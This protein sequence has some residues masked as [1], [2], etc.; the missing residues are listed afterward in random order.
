MLQL[1]HIKKEYKTGDL[2]QKALDDVSL[3][4][5]DNEF[6]AI[7]GPS[8]SGKTT[9]L[10]VIGGLDRYDSGDLIIN[11]IS[12]KKYTD[13]DWDSYRNHT[14]GFVFQSYN[15]I[16]H[17]TVLSNVE[18]ALTISGISGA[19]RRSRATKA[20]EQVGLGDQLHKHPSEMSGGQ[21]QRVAI[22]RALVNNPDILLA[23]EPT[24]ALDSDTSIQVMELLKEVAKDR[25]VVMVTHNPE[26]AEQYATRI[27]RLRDGV[28]QSD[29]A[30]FTPDDSA[31]VPPVHKNL[32]HSSM[33]PL[34]ALAL[35]FN[36]LLTKKTRTLLTAFAGSIGIIGI[37]LILSLSAGVSNYIQEMERSTLS[38]Y[39][40]QISTTGVDLAALL[41]PGSYTSA[42]ANNTN[43]GATS[44]SSTPEG[45][46]TVRELLSQ[47]TEDNSSVNDLASLKKYLDSDECTIS[48]DAASIEY[49]YGIAPLIYRQ[50]K[51]GTVRQIFPDSS[52]SALNNTTSA[53]GIVSS[54][55][56]QSVFTEMAEEPSLYEDQ[57]DVKAGRWP[58]SYNEAV[59]VLNSDGSISDY[60]LYILGIEDDSV[61]MRFLQEYAKNK[62]TQAPTGYGTYPYDT[63]VGLKYKIVTSSDYYVYDEERQIWR[64]R[65]DDEAYVEQLVENSPDLTI[66]G[67]VQPR[68]DAS[69]TIL[70]IGVA[71]THA[72]TYYAIDHAAESEVV[73]QQLA[74]PEVNVLTGERFDADQ[75]ETDLDIS[76]LFSVDTD[77]LKDAFQFDASKLQFD[78]SGA[79]DLQDGSFDF[80][81]ILD[82]SAFQLDLS[83]LDLSDIDMS[84]VELPDMDA[85]DLSQ[86]FADM[87]LSV[88]EDALQ[89]L[90]KKI[91]NGYKR[92]IIG[93]GILNLDKIG[94]SSY[95][96][97][98]QFKQL[99]SES[100]GDLLDTTGLQEQFT[101]SL[102]QNLQGIMTS[103]LQSYSEQ[104]SQKL[105]EALQTKLTAAI[106]TQMSTVMQQLMTQLTTQFSQQIQ[107]AIQNNIA[108]L[109]S[110]VE[111]ALK[112]DPT[113]FQSAVQVNMST[114]DLVDLV[115]MNLQ[116]STT[117]YSSVLGAL[118]YSD[119]AKPGSIWIYPKSFEA[120]NRI[121][122]SL[123][124]YNAA[125]RAQGEE[126]KVIVFSD[127][128]GTLMS[129]VT[130]I[131]DMVSNVLVAF[132]A[133][134]LAV[135]SIMIGVITYISVL[136]RRKEIGILRAI[137]ASK[138]N[139]SEVFNAE[140]FIIGM[141]SGV[142]GVGLCLLL[143]IPGNML[144]H[145]IAGTT[146]VTAVLPPKA[147]LVLIVLA[148][149]LTILGGLIPARSAAK[150]NP[151][152]AL[153][154]E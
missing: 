82:P 63:F 77:M 33:S 8:G 19:E 74:D 89:S 4:L 127:T 131:V 142:I 121:V 115:K 112:I 70:P 151:V 26:L 67:V 20:L 41:D 35:S 36:N 87:D 1:N 46:V 88:S 144:I 147:A 125:M 120:K 113:V 95:M 64:N 145:S 139:V 133:I 118:G 104:L 124:A 106:Q 45:M 39:P 149:L 72:L 73:K 58:E 40:L 148:T 24:G 84:D 31:Q 53:A 132:V 29:T 81:S 116:S 101:A 92:Y 25:L 102:Q 154:S 109:S 86:L 83:D 57:Y 128:V 99:L 66:V 97:S 69:S 56:N 14:I 136:E 91:M 122:D 50:N 141:C 119:Y 54:M 129:A 61:M 65:S 100:M 12:T 5:R 18:L 117:S 135:S 47:L 80:S 3:N 52:L 6:V 16:P 43:V 22:A 150:C 93:N 62:N 44:A 38:E 138:H 21:M 55:T 71:Y 96:E 152:T 153:R 85:L 48:E 146:S 11:G 75:R 59:L 111:D 37:A 108:Q 103:Y 114:D 15:L 49:S 79:F 42:V 10:N 76:S 23:D 17:Q 51:D 130:K 9:L 90:M 140:T 110:Q 7:L 78:L 123:N 13:R 143:L 28:I 2:V 60:A 30:P 137:G 94:F 34:T 126:D 98:D 27:V 32:G 107:S 68:A 134:S 105:G